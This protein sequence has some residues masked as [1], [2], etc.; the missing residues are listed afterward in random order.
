VARL[1]SSTPDPHAD[2]PGVAEFRE[3]EVDA[4]QWPD[5][6]RMEAEEEEAEESG[7]TLFLPKVFL[8]RHGQSAFNLFYSAHARLPPKGQ[9]K[10]SFASVSPSS[11]PVAEGTLLAGIPLL[12]ERKPMTDP[13]LLDA[14]LT[15]HGQ[16]QA[17]EAAHK[18]K[19]LGP[20]PVLG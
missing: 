7:A 1:A 18:R 16:Q 6:G 3:V 15:P 19:S 8:I 11:P 20:C 13:R 14:P 17:R 5:R 10:L 12:R 9:T 4:T 2:S